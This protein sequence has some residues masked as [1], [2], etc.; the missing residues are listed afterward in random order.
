VYHAVNFVN[1]IS[2]DTNNEIK[3]DKENPIKLTSTENDKNV[4]ISRAETA[5]TNAQKSA[6]T[7]RGKVI[8]ALNK[9]RKLRQLAASKLAGATGKAIGEGAKVTR[10]AISEGA[11]ATSTS[12]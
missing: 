10:K 1:N 12:D 3:I 11:K 9:T 4:I 8:E 6:K 5:A 7:A 2:K